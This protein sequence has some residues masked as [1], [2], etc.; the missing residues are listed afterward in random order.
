MLSSQIWP[1]GQYFVKSINQGGPTFFFPRDNNCFPVGSTSITVQA[2]KSIFE[3]SCRGRHTHEFQALHTLPIKC[4]LICS[5]LLSLHQLVEIVDFII[6]WT[7]WNPTNKPLLVRSVIT[8]LN[9][10]AKC[11]RFVRK[12]Y[13]YFLMAVWKCSHFRLFHAQREAPCVNKTPF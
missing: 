4:S 8:D 13:F 3:R 2:N 9:D 10:K 6:H 11:V 7:F 1:P 12:S 5:S